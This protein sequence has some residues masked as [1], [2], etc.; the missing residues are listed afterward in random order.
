MAG[1]DIDSR[2]RVWVATETAGIIIY[3]P[4]D[5]SSGSFFLMILFSKKLFR[6]LMFL[7]IAIRL[8]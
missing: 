2:G 8:E 1:I 3:D 6:R 4:A 7:F 5:N